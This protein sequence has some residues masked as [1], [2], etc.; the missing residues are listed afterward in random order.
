MLFSIVLLCYHQKHRKLEYKYM[1]LV[2]S[3]SSANPN[4]TEEAQSSMRELPLAETCGLDPNDDEE[5]DSKY[6]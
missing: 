3:S 5:D 4:Y 2:A 6:S 1:K